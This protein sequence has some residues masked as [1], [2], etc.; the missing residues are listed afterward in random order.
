MKAAR[1]GSGALALA[2][3]CGGAQSALAPAGLQ[4]EQLA[5]VFWWMTGGSLAIWLLVLGI[6]LYAAHSPERQSLAGP[7]RL[8]VWGGVILPT[9]VLTLVLCF[10]LALIPKHVDPSTPSRL[11]VHVSGEQY[12]WR[13]K[14]LPEHGAPVELA[15]EIHLPVG[16]EVDF[17]LDSRDVI[18]SFWIPSLGGKVDMI[19]GRQTR[20][21]LSPQRTGT[22][23][24]QC[25]EYCGTSHALMAFG[26][27][28]QERPEF[29]RW[30][31]A[32]AA[33]ARDASD[34][35]ARDGRNVLLAN[36]CGACHALRGTPADGVLGPDLTHV[37]GR[38][39]LAAGVLPNAEA[40]FSRWLAETDRLKPG[41]HMPAFGMLA[42]PEMRALAAYLESLE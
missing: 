15:N 17:L 4:A 38:G 16:E 24:G 34:A 8:I 33:P 7:R 9:L 21:R 2:L 22:F 37:G 28:V 14:Y 30:L 1:Y 5:R 20:L 27:V 23:R 19:P 29:E 40:G 26:V 36:G 39:S 6:A 41:A 35:L 25:A 11:R 31:A 12:W 18:H 10:G 32:Q 42:A 3:G 13:V